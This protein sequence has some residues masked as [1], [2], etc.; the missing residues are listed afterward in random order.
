MRLAEIVALLDRWYDPAWAEPWDAVGLV[1]GDPDDEVRSVLFAVDP[2]EAVVDEALA[3]GVDLLVVHHP[4]LLSPV[5]SVAATTAKGRVVHRLVRGGVALLTAHTNADVPA[6]GVNESIAAALGVRGAR[7]LEPTDGTVPDAGRPG[8]GQ[9]G[10][11]RAARRTSTACARPW[12]RP[13]PAAL[14]AYDSCS[15][16][17]PGEGRF[18]PLEGADPALGR[19]GEV[20]V[21]AEVRL[22][23]LYPRRLRR[24]VVAAL[25][26]AHPY[27]EP[28]FDLVELADVPGGP[29]T[30]APSGAARARVRCRHAVTAGSGSWTE[31]MSLRA[32]AERV[33]ARRCPGPPTAYA[34]PGTPTARCARSRCWPA[35]G[36]RCWR[37]PAPPAP[38]S[39]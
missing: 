26:A 28:A 23:T 34:S 32:F 7:V 13:A 12:S 1:C 10:G 20:E 39:S 3:L 21:V 15:F 8:D 17:T 9:A 5:S 31:P 38:T 36:S 37:R 35:R 11:L 4:L 16:S 2:V 24:E 14:G 33:D 19:V 6:D 25:R 22:E 27:E 18:R 29:V 30:T